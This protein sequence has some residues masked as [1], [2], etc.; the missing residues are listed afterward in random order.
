MFFRIKAIEFSKNQLKVKR[1]KK[2]VKM[3]KNRFNSKDYYTS[4]Q[5]SDLKTPELEKF[6]CIK[7]VDLFESFHLTTYFPNS[8]IRPKCY[9]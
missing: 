1:M 6:F 5:F 4:T 7:V 3:G 9:G 8:D 2:G